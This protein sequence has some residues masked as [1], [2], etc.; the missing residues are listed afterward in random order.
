MSRKLL[1]VSCNSQQHQSCIVVNASLHQTLHYH[2]RVED[3]ESPPQFLWQ[4]QPLVLQVLIC[5][6]KKAVSML[7]VA[8]LL[9]LFRNDE[10]RSSGLHEVPESFVK[11]VD[12]AGIF[13]CAIGFSH[14]IVDERV[15]QGIIASFAHDIDRIV[16]LLLSNFEEELQCHR[17]LFTKRVVLGCG[18]Q[19]VSL[20]IVAC[21]GHVLFPAALVTQRFLVSFHGLMSL[22][23]TEGVRIVLGDEKE[24]DGT[25]HVALFLAVLS[26]AFGA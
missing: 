25:R 11:A 23:E 4:S 3:H 17:I 19:H 16:D 20:L 22:S 8:H 12:I 18:S 14:E 6:E 13:R 26:H 10:C 21:D 5:A 24:L 2:V 15:R 7:V 1:N 9:L